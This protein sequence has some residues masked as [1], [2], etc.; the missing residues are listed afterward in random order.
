MT[1]IEKTLFNEL[2]ADPGY[3]LRA[4]NDV[5]LPATE[6]MDEYFPYYFVLAYIPKT[7]TIEECQAMYVEELIP[8]E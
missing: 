1:I 5:Y 7:R 3:W 4:V 6:D 8:T 2:H